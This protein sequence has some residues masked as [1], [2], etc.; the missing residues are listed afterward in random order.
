MSSLCQVLLTDCAQRVPAALCGLAV[1]VDSLRL[2]VEAQEAQ[3]AAVAT[4]GAPQASPT[5]ADAADA[6]DSASPMEE[7]AQDH[8]P[9]SASKAHSAGVTSCL[10]CTTLLTLVL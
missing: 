8:S 4:A 5:Q 9:V 10:G 7:D 1:F 2:L 3:Q 6:D